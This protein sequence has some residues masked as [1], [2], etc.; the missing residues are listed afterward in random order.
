MDK[1]KILDRLLAVIEQCV[2]ESEQPNKKEAEVAVVKAVNEMKQLATFVVLEPQDASGETADL[3]GDWYD[4]ES[5][6]EAMVS[7]NMQCR[8]AGLE[9][10][11]LLSNEDVIIE[12]SYISPCDFTVEETGQFVKKGTWLQTWKF[13]NQELWQDVLSGH[14][15][16]V[17]IECSA[18]GY[19]VEQ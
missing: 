12:E 16:G 15:C 9:H 18:V 6:R 14:F 2:G 3:H 10:Q 4:A 13:N 5:I 7:F 11:G 1:D 8:K 17:S 19:E